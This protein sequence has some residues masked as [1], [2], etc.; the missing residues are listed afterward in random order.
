[1]TEAVKGMEYEERVRQAS[2]VT[3]EARRRRKHNKRG[4]KLN[5]H[6][7]GPEVFI[8]PFVDVNTWNALPEEA[9]SCTDG[10]SSYGELYI[11][12]L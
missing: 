11:Y 1:M 2:L 12:K 9:V 6:K 8:Q 5:V 4:H 7:K 10:Y 3:L